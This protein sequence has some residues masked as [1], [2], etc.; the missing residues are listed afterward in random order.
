MMAMIM[1]T[2]LEPSTDEGK[3]IHKELQ[4]L[5]EAA[6]VQQAQNSAKRRHPK[7]SVVHIFSTHGATEGH[8]ALTM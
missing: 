6:A 1:R 4:D 7:A 3:R 5:L 2:A 8:H